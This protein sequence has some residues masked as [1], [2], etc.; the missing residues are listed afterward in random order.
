MTLEQLVYYLKGS[1]TVQADSLY[2]ERFLTVCMKRNLDI[3]DIRQLG[4]RRLCME[5][6]I[7]AF[8]KIRPVCRR[9]RTR[10]T[11]LKRRGLPFLL[12]RL[13]HRKFAFL[14]LLA[15]VLFLWYTTCHIMGITVIGNQRINTETVLEHL[16]RSGVSMGKSTAGIDSDQIRNRMM[17]DL[18]QLAWV[19]INVSGSRIYVEI[20]ERLEKPAAPDFSQPCHLIASKD[21][22]ILSIEAREGQTMVSVGSGVVAGDLLVSGLMDTDT[23]GFRTVHAWGDVYART[24]YEKT[25]EYPL[26][27][28]EILETGEEKTRYSLKILNRTLPLFWGKIPYAQYSET[29]E[30]AEYRLPLERLPSLWI[31]KTVYREKYE[32]ERTRQVSEA[33]ETARK[34][35]FDALLETVPPEAEILDREL[36]H[37][38]TEQGAVLATARVVCKENIAEKS[39]VETEI[40]IDKTAVLDYDRQKRI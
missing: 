24:Y 35:L 4:E 1:L 36:T 15:A 33:L 16:A 27:F 39:A 40:S 9:T 32:Q 28:T 22:E 3:R 25:E 10:L 37:T 31:T 21:G 7:P 23:G 18:D 12:Q 30:T 6:S 5:M 26:T 14:G 8:R 34:E 38:L 2:P 20:V 11:I 17:R 19:G 13:R 29:T